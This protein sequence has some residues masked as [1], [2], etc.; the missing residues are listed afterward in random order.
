MCCLCYKCDWQISSYGSDQVVGRIYKQWA[1]V[2]REMFTDA[3]Q[4][5][6]SCK[7]A[8]TMHGVLFVIYKLLSLKHSA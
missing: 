6:V 3:D 7:F 4:F 5:G 1:G 2:V 8:F